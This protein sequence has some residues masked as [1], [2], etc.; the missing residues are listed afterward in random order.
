[1]TV[2]TL[3]S[4]LAELLQ[5][6]RS[7]VGPILAPASMEVPSHLRML[8]GT[9]AQR[10]VTMRVERRCGDAWASLLTADILDSHGQTL[11]ATVIGLPDPRSCNPVL[12]VDLI[13]LGGR[14]SLFAVD[15]APIDD[16]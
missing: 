12:G 1:M 2:N 8:R 7:D 5:V 3:S 4:S 13:A 16:G 14:L 6:V 15:L 11:S 9:I 10:P